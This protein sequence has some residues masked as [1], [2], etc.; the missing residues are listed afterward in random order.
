MKRTLL[1][2]LIL[3][4][5]IGLS[6]AQKPEIIG[7]WL[8]ERVEMDDE[9]QQP[10]MVN[11]FQ[12][13]G[14]MLMMGMEV[15]TWKFNKK[16]DGIVLKSDF[17][18]D[19]DGEM[20][21][22][23]YT[24][25]ELVFD[26]DGV[27]LF[28]LRLKEAEIIAGNIN[29]GLF[30]T[31]EV[32]DCPNAGLNT[33]LTFTEPDLMSIIEKGGGYESTSSGTWIFNEQKMSLQ[34]IGPRSE[35]IFF[36]KSKVLAVDEETLS[37]ENNGK[38]Y[39]ARRKVSN[40]NKI[41]R[42]TFNE[43]D[44]YTDDG[45]YKYEEEAR[46]LPWANWSELKMGLLNVK[47]LVYS[48]SKLIEGTETFD[49]EILRANVEASLEEEGY[50]ID[51]IFYGYDSFNPPDDTQIPP[52]PSYYNDLYP[53]NEYTY[54][55]VGKEQITT[56]AGTFDCTVIEALGD[57]D[58]LRKL[59]MIDDRLGIYAKIIQED[60]DENFGHYAIYEL[61]EIKTVD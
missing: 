4:V 49:S 58:L 10:F 23:S 14:A 42:L 8:L 45:D 32:K 30:G 28:Y 47:E 7:T 26:K 39:K 9:I 1:L 60:P 56:A 46:N 17:D 41:E 54:R 24:E 51:F 34:M 29:S 37:L 44:F 6:N 35:D 52:N 31:W 59:W 12:K 53:L 13:G 18:K 36:G 11:E 27:K 61:Q 2:A 21:I 43:D 20:L 40:S 48:Y 16:G 3:F 33:L 25:K 22:L 15:A 57:S 5:F 38:V 55:I 50:L 19:F